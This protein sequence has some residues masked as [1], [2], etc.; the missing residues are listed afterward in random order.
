M[1]LSDEKF[2]EELAKGKS[3][4][5]DD[6]SAGGSPRPRQDEAGGPLPGRAGGQDDAFGGEVELAKA[7][8]FAPPKTAKSP[9][10]PKIRD[11][12][13]EG[14]LAIDV[15]QTPN[16]IV[17]ESAIAGIKPED[18]DITIEN[19]IVTIRGER[20][21]QM[22]EEAKKYYYEEC[23]WGTFSR[24]IILPEEVDGDKAEASIKDG[25]LTL[26]VPKVARVKKRKITIR[27][28]A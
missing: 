3:S 5:E 17:V 15:Y 22:I 25:V 11:D 26:R 24:Q 10:L 19:D 4:A 6:S 8:T 1:D 27:Q 7:S 20:K 18:L 23:Y 13:P 14:Q 21:K 16:D 2:F 28:E 12:E 9:P